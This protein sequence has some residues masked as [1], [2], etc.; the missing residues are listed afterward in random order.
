MVFAKN[1][2]DTCRVEV[3]FS[4]SATLV[5]GLPTNF[6]MKPIVLNAAASVEVEP[7]GAEEKAAVQSALEEPEA[8]V[9]A[10][11]IRRRRE[12]ARE[13]GLID[14]VSQS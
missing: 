12:A 10:N 7:E 1:K 6:G 5:L 8:S 4:D 3:E 14:M 2:Y 13:C 9:S 11:E